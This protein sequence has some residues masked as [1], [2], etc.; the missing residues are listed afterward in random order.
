MPAASTQCELQTRETRNAEGIHFLAASLLILAPGLTPEARGQDARPLA[1]ETS[2]QIDALFAPWDSTQS[3]GCVLG[4]SRNGN[5]VYTRGYG[6]S[7][8]EYDVA[9]TPDSVFQIGSI[10]NITVAVTPDRHLVVRRYK[11][12]PVMLEALEQDTFTSR[13]FGT[14]S[15]VRT[16]TGEITGLRNAD[17]RTRGV[18]YTRCCSLPDAKP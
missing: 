9:I 11:F 3:P 10:A 18:V 8:L 17:S 4:V 7:N 2:Q 12:G 13:G 5:V 6:M 1:A 16:P 15:F 14:V